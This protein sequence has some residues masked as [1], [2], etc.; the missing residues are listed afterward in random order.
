MPLVRRHLN[1]QV[2]LQLLQHHCLLDV[3]PHY[4][5]FRAH[6]NGSK[7]CLYLQ[8]SNCISHIQSFRFQQQPLATPQELELELDLRHN[9]ATPQELELEL[10]LRQA[11]VIPLGLELELD[12]RQ[13]NMAKPT[14]LEVELDL[15]RQAVVTPQGLE[16]VLYLRQVMV[17]RSGVEEL[18]LDVHLEVA[19]NAKNFCIH[20]RL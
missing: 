20:D 2:L 16:Q 1:R 4:P 9:M 18:E 8:R 3:F 10:D 15:R 19:N 7:T 11:M 12:L 13:H 5:K 14:G 6:L 17:M